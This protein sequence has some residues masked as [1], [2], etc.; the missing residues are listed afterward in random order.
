MKHTA[1]VL[2][3]IAFAAAAC[4]TTEPPLSM[5]SPSPMVMPATAVPPRTQAAER[6]WDSALVIVRA[7]EADLATGGLPTVRTHVVDLEQALASADDAFRAAQA[8]SNPRYVLTDGQTEAVAAPL[9][10]AADGNRAG[11]TAVVPV[12]N[13]YPRASFFLG[14]YYNEVRRPADALRVLD[15]GLA[16]PTAFP[17]SRGE[18]IPL[19]TI[20]R[21]AALSGLMRWQDSLANY[22]RGLSFERVPPNQRAV[23][24]R[25]RGF[26]LIELGRLAEAEAAYRDSLALDPNNQIAARELGYIQRLRAGGPRAPTEII[27][28]MPGA[29]ISPPQR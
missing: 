3:V 27:P 4:T 28:V 7:T 12:P 5:G 19:L 26:A 8:S 17:G 11:R 13:P 16:L 6:P 23:M 2:A 21:G 1:I 9:L 20:E 18:T 15:I 22:D 29:G 25:G 14:S 10:A 24:L